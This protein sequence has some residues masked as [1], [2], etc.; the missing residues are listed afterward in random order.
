M[1]AFL[2]KRTMPVAFAL[3]LTMLGFLASCGQS[4]QRYLEKANALSASGKYDEAALNYRKA[5]Q[6]DPKSGEAQYRLGL[7]ELKLGHSRDAYN[8]LLSANTLLPDRKDVKIT[9]ADFLLVVYFSDK[10]RPAAY[11]QQLISLSD[12]LLAQDSNSYDGFRIKGNLAWLDGHLKDSR[13]FFRKA[14]AA[15]PWQPDLILSWAQVLFQDGQSAEG[16]RLAL[17]LI[18]KHKDAARIYDLLYQNYRSQNR[19]AEA[20][21]ILRTKLDNNP[22]QTTY[23]LQLAAFYVA[24]GKRDQMTAVLKHL[25]DDPKTFPDARIRIGDFYGTLHEW[26][27]AL[28]QYEE[29]ARENPKL[30]TEYL[31]RI[32]DAW[33]AQG[34]GDKAAAVV[35]DILKDSP[36]DDA[37]K[38]VNASLLIKTGNPDKIQTALNDL[39]ELVKRE[40]DNPLLRF[41]LGRGMVAKGDLDGARSQFQESIKV[42]SN[43]LP[44]IMALAELSQNKRDFNEAVRYANQALKVNPKLG[45]ARLLRAGAFIQTQKYSE[46]RSELTGL[47]SDFPQDVD[48]QFQLAA[49]DLAEK[50]YPQAEAR[51]Q[52]LYE[53]DKLRAL[54]GLV[55]AYNAQGEFDK[56]ISRLTLELGKT[57]NTA[58][59]HSMLADT[60][61]RARKY[62]LALEQYQQLQTM[63]VRSEQLQLRLGAAYQ[64]KG[65][66]E[67]AIASFQSAK[68][69]A[70]RDPVSAGALAD[71]QR[72]AGH[73]AEAIV[74]YRR[75]LTLDAENENAMNNLAYLLLETGG[76]ADEAQRLVEQ[77]LR[78]SP[79]NPNFADT[80]GMVYMKKNLEDSALQVF[81]GLTTRF[82]DNPVFRYH[83]ALSLSQKGQKAKAKTELEVALRK[84]P[85]EDLRKDIQTTLAKIQQ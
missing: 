85:P 48:V 40:P 42:R 51:L 38:A 3:L 55:N 50:N 66:Y 39:Q 24:A 80:L 8:A 11:Y 13:E 5:I 45:R 36:N 43:Y 16:E 79:R 10:S 21:R 37:A 30:R 63:G 83:Y 73:S 71:A 61:M 23:A 33:L 70:P 7:A 68:E 72:V 65:Q 35:G 49:L 29:G 69:L 4:A 76:S 81:G 57:P 28:H 17:D 46:A 26:D 25:L 64:L 18:Q 78:K 62:D 32:A 20:E 84:A 74:N 19:L 31:K 44:S 12:A 77:A 60:A 34:N 58:A 54:A 75:L 67:K 52:Q 47:A 53:K 9:L 22:S 27:E 15:K 1:A 14:N 82:P 59:V 41:A 6:K 2:T 56:A